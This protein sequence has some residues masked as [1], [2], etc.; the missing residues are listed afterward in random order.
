[1]QHSPIAGPLRL[2]QLVR[3]PQAVRRLIGLL[4]QDEPPADPPGFSLNGL[5]DDPDPTGKGDDSSTDPPT[6]PGGTD[7]TAKSKVAAQN[8][9]ID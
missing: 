3:H 7:T 1:V 8:Q 5:S 4:Q 9:A 2:L 6:G